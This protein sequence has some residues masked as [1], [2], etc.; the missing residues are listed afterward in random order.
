MGA[1][2]RTPS[3]II[4]EKWGSLDLHIATLDTVDDTDTY[5]S[6][7]KRVVGYWANGTD[8]PTTQTSGKIDVS[9]SSGTFTFNCGEDDRSCMLYV[10]SERTV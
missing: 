4:R 10:L 7:I 1:A 2:A 8:D 9:E 5:A 6:G 3:L